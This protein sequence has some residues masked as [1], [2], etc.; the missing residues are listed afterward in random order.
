MYEN[1]T[2]Y[3]AFQHLHTYI[4]TRAGI[5]SLSLIYLCMYVAVRTLSSAPLRVFIYLLT[6][7]NDSW[8]LPAFVVVMVM[9]LLV[10]ASASSFIV[11]IFVT[12]IFPSPSPHK[13]VHRFHALF[14]SLP[15]SLSLLIYLL[16]VFDSWT[17]N[18]LAVIWQFANIESGQTKMLHTYIS[19]WECRMHLNTYWTRAQAAIHRFGF[20]KCLSLTVITF[21]ADLYISSSELD[22]FWRCNLLRKPI[23]AGVS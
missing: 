5:N 20:L 22:R 1:S 16:L 18:F 23:P 7:N 19:K 10:V 13:R 12:T 15:L 8:Q 3:C 14:P 9:V 6:V 21:F 11:F 2:D 4:H 17:I